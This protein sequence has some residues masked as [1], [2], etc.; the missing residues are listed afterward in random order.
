MVLLKGF[1]EEGFRF[2]SNYCS[3]KGKHLV[4]TFALNIPVLDQGM[5][6]GRSYIAQ[7]VIKS[8]SESYHYI[9]QLKCEAVRYYGNIFSI[10]II[11]S[12]G[13]AT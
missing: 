1:S 7:S 10:N 4:S 11:S 8:A 12:I 6:T 5:T 3:E 2:F 9:S 13:I